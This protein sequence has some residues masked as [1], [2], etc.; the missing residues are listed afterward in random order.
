M[1]PW[2]EGPQATH[3]YKASGTYEI[4]LMAV[5]D[6]LGTSLARQ[7]VNVEVPDQQSTTT[8]APSTTTAAEP[9]PSTE[10]K[11]SPA[12]TAAPVAADPKAPS[13]GNGPRL[14]AESCTAI[15]SSYERRAS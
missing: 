10:G 1:T 6:D 4:V 8:T 5:D 11:A 3:S 13:S 7:T 2:A 14:V 15:T 9:P 12:T